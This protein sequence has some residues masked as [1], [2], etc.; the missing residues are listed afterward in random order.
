MNLRSL[1]LLFFVLITALSLSAQEGRI[2]GNVYDATTGEPIIYGNITVEGT[3]LGANTDLNGFFTIAK[4]PAGNQTLKAS[5]LGYDSLVVDV[6]V[7]ENKTIL[8]NF[9]M[10]SGGI[11]INT[12]DISAQREQARTE[13][14]I[15]KIQVSKKRIK[16][17]PSTGADADIV[18]YL[19][20]IPGVIST[21]D[22]GGQLYIRGGSPVQ[23]KIA[24][25]GLLIYNPFHSIGFYSV[26][27]TELIK[28]VDVFTGGFNAEHGGRISAVVDIST[29]DGNKTRFGGQ[30]SAS[31]FSVKGLIEGPIIPFREGKSNASFVLTSKRSII[32]QTSSSFYDYAS[33]NDSIGLP[34]FFN[35]TYGKISFNSSNGSKLNLFG[36]GF[37]DTY[38]NP[39]VAQINWQ[40]IGG[41]ANFTL[42]PNEANML[43]NGVLG[44][45][46]YKTAIG[47]GTGGDRSSGI[48]EITAEIDFTIF[49][50]DSEVNYGISLKSI[51]T[52]FDFV[53][54][55][56]L[57][58]SQFQNTTEFAAFGKYRKVIN[59]LVIEP[60][61]RVQYYASLAT[62]SFEPRLGFK[63]NI[64][65]KLRFKGAAGMYSQNILSTSTER[66]VVNLF[67]GFLSGPES[68]IADIGGG[69]TDDKLQRSNHLVGGFELD[70]TNNIQLN[71]EGYYKDFPQLVVVNRNKLSND[72]PDYSKEEGEAYGIDFSVKY[73]TPKSYLWLTY[74]LGKVN[75]FDGFST[76]PTVFD[77]RHNANALFTYNLDKTGDFSVSVRYNLGSGFPFTQ[78]Q[79]FYNFIPFTEGVSTDV[80][81]ENPEDIGIIYSEDRNDGRLPYYHR[82]DVSMTKK[83]NFSKYMNLELVASVSNATNRD[84]I[85]YFDRLA[86]ERVDQLPIIPSLGAKLNF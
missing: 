2:K 86:Y 71:V 46:N 73:E 83:F 50:D 11:T 13:V 57:R 85:F 65:D 64:T 80:L 54:P 21:G 78:T 37:N 61:L 60:G 41:G 79:S 36:F 6:V 4:V 17:L 9:Y 55:F 23:N 16:A 14:Q 22:Q 32:D 72:D 38:D 42:I 24:L 18:Q 75:R 74:S 5:Y 15:S 77:R 12:V 49:G 66:D 28:N 63:Y 69:F 62:A 30:V 47:E 52:D 82:V 43:I 67:S 76:F 19:Q 39:D 81:T 26:F 58:L 53:N 25:D 44:Y 34:F 7:T 84:N 59:K 8:Q 20:I 70:L 27:E 48:K 31:P 29:R 40:N 35:D 10:Q 45:T 51:R 56:G 68:Q 33:V 1:Y 3:Q